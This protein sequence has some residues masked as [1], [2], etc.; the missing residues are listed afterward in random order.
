MKL[1]VKLATAGGST[2][3]L[4]VQ[5]AF[6]YLDGKELMDLGT[7]PLGTQQFLTR[8]PIGLTSFGLD[9]RLGEKSPA[10][11]YRLKLT[12]TDKQAPPPA[13]SAVRELRFV[14]R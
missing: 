7:V 2:A 14:L 8:T 9:V 11:E 10:G 4:Q 12:I 13:K 3:I 1:C 5:G 6:T